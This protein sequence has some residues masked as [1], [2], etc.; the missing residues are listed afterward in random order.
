MTEPMTCTEAELLLGVLVLGAIDP[1]ERYGVESHVDT[2]PRCAT[3]L[4]ELAV[5]PGLLHRLDLEDVTAGLT[6]VSADFTSRVLAAGTE[7]ARERAERRRRRTRW[8]SLAAAVL[9]LAGV[10]VAIPV[11]LHRS[12]AGPTAAQGTPLVV[13]GTNPA[14]SV[15]ATVTMVP[16]ATGTSLELALSGV[17]P[18]EHCQL[19]AVDSSGH[20][21][22]TSTWVASYRGVA[23][24][25]GS[26]AFPQRSIQ[27]L[28]VVTNDGRTLVTV[29]VPHPASA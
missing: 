5:L 4:A 27:T 1:A 26:T 15:S 28:L 6:P 13:T 3:T 17:E 14:T 19:V 22:V 29:P 23:A 16:Q 9:L 11:A 18:G 2:C 10:G 7:L 21:E 24:V 12:P 20:R 25:S 8:V